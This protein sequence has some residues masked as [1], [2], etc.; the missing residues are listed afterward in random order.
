MSGIELISTTTVTSSLLGTNS[1]TK[2]PIKQLANKKG[3]NKVKIC[4]IVA[5]KFMPYIEKL[6]PK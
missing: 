5:S 6:A 2:I 3:S 4:E 1:P